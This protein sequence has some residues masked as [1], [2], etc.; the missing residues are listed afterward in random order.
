MQKSS[1]RLKHFFSDVICN[2]QHEKVSEICIV[3][4]QQCCAIFVTQFVCEKNKTSCDSFFFR[5][6]KIGEKQMNRLMLLLRR[7]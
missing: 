2:E 5:Q 1:K 6:K 4:Y 7:E 3:K